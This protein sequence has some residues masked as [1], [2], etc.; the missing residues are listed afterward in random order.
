M[1]ESAYVTKGTRVR[2]QFLRANP[3]ASLSGMQTKFSCEAVD[4]TGTI[5]HFR[6]DDPV[7][8]EVVKVYLDPDGDC[9]L[10]R[11]RPHGCTHEAGHVEVDSKHIV[12][13]LPK[14]GP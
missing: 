11:V 4:V 6:T 12:G 3:G 2:A 7:K 5:A 13:V 8:Q 1:S 10:P 9:R 14:E